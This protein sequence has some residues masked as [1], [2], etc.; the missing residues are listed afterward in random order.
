M[1]GCEIEEGLKDMVLSRRVRLDILVE[2]AYYFGILEE[3]N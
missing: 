3:K 2:I 1:L